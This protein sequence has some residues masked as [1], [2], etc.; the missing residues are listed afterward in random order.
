MAVV[1]GWCRKSDIHSKSRLKKKFK[2]K[3]KFRTNGCSRNKIWTVCVR[4]DS[5]SSAMVR[6]GRHLPRV[7]CINL[8][9]CQLEKN[10]H[11]CLSVGTNVY[12][13]YLGPQ[14]GFPIVDS[15]SGYTCLA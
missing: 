11:H 2:C 13:G 5:A 14:G 1:G 6:V 15:R 3:S 4:V 12:F 9:F 8:A 10:H 7:V